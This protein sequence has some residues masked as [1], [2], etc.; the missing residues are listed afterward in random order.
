MITKFSE[1]YRHT[2]P[3]APRSSGIIKEWDSRVLFK[4]SKIH[5]ALLCF[6]IRT[7]LLTQ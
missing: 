1:K 2:E 4:S 5:P 7:V 3:F 6:K